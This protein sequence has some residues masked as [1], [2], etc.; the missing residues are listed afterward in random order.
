MTPPQRRAPP[1]VSHLD[2]VTTIQTPRSVTLRA[3]GTTLLLG[4]DLLRS[5][6]LGAAAPSA[7]LTGAD[8]S[9]SQFLGTFFA[10]KGLVLGL[11][12][13]AEVTAL[14]AP[15]GALRWRW[16]HASASP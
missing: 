5:Y 15:T 12:A 16:R 6:P 11:S 3:T 2:R 9:V 14:D 4:G 7:I 10:V 8:A 13:T 1:D